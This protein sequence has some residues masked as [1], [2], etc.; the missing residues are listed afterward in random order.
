MS[1]HR[2]MSDT[3]LQKRSTK[4]L[5]SRSAFNR[6]TSGVLMEGGVKDADYINTVFR[7]CVGDNV[8]QVR[9]DKFVGSIAGA[10]AVGHE[11][12]RAMNNIVKAGYHGFGR[13][14]VVS[15]L[16]PHQPAR[17][18]PMAETVAQSPGLAL[19]LLVSS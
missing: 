7:W 4:R 13:C 8:R 9:D 18:S 17:L 5:V 12:E 16:V 19:R 6:A 1:R 11:I 3:S 14:G 15:Q 10:A 2:D